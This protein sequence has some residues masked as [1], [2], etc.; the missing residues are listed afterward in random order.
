V[1]A[2]FGATLLI[3]SVLLFVLEPMIARRLL[4]RFGGSPA[5]WNTGMV[6]FQAGLLAGYAYAHVA[7][8][9]LGVR[10]QA[11]L[12][13]GLLVLPLGIVWAGVSGGV[14]RETS[15][16]ASSTYAA[17]DL[18]G[19][20]LTTA[21]PPFF[22]VATTAP[23]LQRW[24]AAIDHPTARD[25]YFL[26]GASNLGSLLGLLAYP[27]VIEPNLRLADQERLWAAGYFVLAA[28]TIACAVAVWTSA[29]GVPPIAEGGR[30]AADRP[31]LGLRLR[32]TILAFVPSSLLLGVTTFL[33]TD[34]AP[35]PLLW[36]VPLS[37][38]LLSFVLVFARR[39][40]VP[41]GLSV[42]AL[43]MAVMVLVP[44]MAAGL[45]QPFWI[46]I[47]LLTFFLSAMVC[48]GE[49]ARIRP[50]SR[51]L[52]TYYLAI[53]VGGV[54]GGIVNALGAPLVFDRV[55]EYPL[56][57]FLACLCLPG[58][59]RDA[60]GRGCVREGLLPLVIGSL[61]AGLVRDVGGVTE[62]ALGP[63]A[64]MLASG[65]AMLLAVT[66]R[67]RPLRFAMGVAAVLLAGG[68][69]DGVDGRVLHRERTFFGV[70]RVTEV[71]DRDGRLHRLFHG[72]TLH[73]Q[74]RVAPGWRREPLAY[75]HR[76][77]PIGQVFEVVH[78][79]PGARAR[80][81]VVGLGAGSLAA[82]ALPGERW[83]F[84]EIDPAVVRIARDPQAFTFLQDSRAG[85]T[86]VIVGDARLRLREAPDRVT[87]LLVLDAFSSDAIPTHLLTREALELYRS[88]LA[89]GGLIALHLSNRTIDLEPVVGRLARDA[90][91]VARVRHDRALTS[92]ERRAGKSTS[93]WAVLAAQASALGALADD[94]RWRPPRLEPGDRVWTD[95]YSNVVGHLVLHPL[96]AATAP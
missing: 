77:G 90:G 28:L 48:H 68:L 96:G 91:L 27:L 95:D 74:Q 67:A 82:Y 16:I 57:V 12:H 45:V 54:L 73:G 1:P 78:A 22:V 62:S 9:Q 88:K 52:T 8:A 83:T 87:D 80:V 18:L 84:Y 38:Y 92:E 56:G 44:A 21:G 94:P 14:P 5:V 30:S 65:L 13:A 20:L 33:T 59:G 39:P 3:G 58:V 72:N 46:P 86:D 31:G 50:P 37:L 32:W 49:L 29:R 24:F 35:I 34:L 53:A 43:P 10:R 61:M 64:V 2:L 81:A 75:Y 60:T 89:G 15:P 66:A 11:A 79:R 42:R 36:A 71:A 23:L 55:V 41:H 70:L 93:I 47:H 17:G 85:T 26:Y 6:F 63:F 7:T 40:L 25:P 51:D 69:S 4:P 76:S 19:L